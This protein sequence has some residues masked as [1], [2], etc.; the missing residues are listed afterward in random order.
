MRSHLFVGAFL[1]AAVLTV[2]AVATTGDGVSPVRQSAAITLTEPTLVGSTIVQG[3]VLFIHDA[4]KMSRGEP[5]TTIQLFDP[6]N[7]PGEELVSF[8]CIPKARRVVSTFT[9]TTRP[10]IE[11]GFGRVLV[12]YQFA[13][14][15]E[16][17]GVPS[18]KPALAH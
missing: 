14:D 8:H 11:L 4:E 16:G 1:V 10:N 15:A 6:E 12:E 5:C 17:H 7:G 3:P 9:V 13:G 18:S 2:G